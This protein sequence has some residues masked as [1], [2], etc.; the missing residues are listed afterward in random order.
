MPIESVLVTVAVLFVF[1]VFILAVA[2][3]QATWR[4]G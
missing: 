4:R 2:F 3:A 1:A